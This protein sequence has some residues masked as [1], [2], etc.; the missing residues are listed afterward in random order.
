[1]VPRSTVE[2]PIATWIPFLLTN[3]GN[4][5]TGLQL[6]NLHR[7]HPI[8]QWYSDRTKLYSAYADSIRKRIFS[9]NQRN[10]PASNWPMQ[11]KLYNLNLQSHVVPFKWLQASWYTETR[12]IWHRWVNFLTKR[13]CQPT[14]YCCRWYY[15]ES[16]SKFFRGTVY[17]K[18]TSSSIIAIFSTVPRAYLLH[19]L[20]YHPEVNISHKS[21][22]FLRL[23]SGICF[24]FDQSGSIC[25][26]EPS[27]N[28][29]WIYGVWCRKS[30]RSRCAETP[31]IKFSSML[32]AF[33]GEK[34]ILHG[35]KFY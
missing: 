9:S 2:P 1:M 18:G 27:K 4:W 21:V 8:L 16:D 15:K 25:A 23:L 19:L 22:V 17:A 31:P 6:L 12:F 32:E 34:L 30:I 24:P 26:V 5:Y 7:Q 10:S 29:V 14:Q 11:A 28:T 20:F 35:F 3:A 33:F 13:C